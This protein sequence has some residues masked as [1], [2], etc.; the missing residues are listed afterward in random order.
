MISDEMVREAFQPMLDTP[1][2]YLN[3]LMRRQ[4]VQIYRGQPRQLWKNEH[5]D[6]RSGGCLRHMTVFKQ[7]NAIPKYCFDCYKV[8]IA[9]R[10]VG[11][12]FKLLM[13]FEKIALPSDN[14]RKCMCEG[15]DAFWAVCLSIFARCLPQF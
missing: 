6:D 12:L 9:H 13:V 8:E 4:F 7:F 2:G 3:P 15:M 10:T 1:G 11:E 5:K 14:S